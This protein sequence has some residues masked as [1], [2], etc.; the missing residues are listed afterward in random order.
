V[1]V[2]LAALLRRGIRAAHWDHRDLLIAAVALGA[3]L[4]LGD[5]TSIT[6]GRRPPTAREYDVLAVTLNERLND[7]GKD[8]P[9]RLW[10]QLPDT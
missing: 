4:D 8:H 2:D 7:I 1:T 3:N 5:I 10:H 6:S 9:M